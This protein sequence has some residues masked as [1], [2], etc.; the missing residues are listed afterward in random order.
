MTTLNRVDQAVLLLKERLRK[1]GENQGKRAEGAPV[2]A[3]RAESESRLT[4]IRQLMRQ[5][6]VGDQELRRALVRALL[7][8]SL[9]EELTTSLNFQSIADE[10]VRLIEETEGGRELLERALG[11][12]S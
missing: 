1:L 10:V 6:D 7:A 11:E 9:G 4:P 5:Q 12:L 2:S 8:D 3:N